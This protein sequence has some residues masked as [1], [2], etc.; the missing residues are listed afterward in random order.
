MLFTILIVLAVVVALVVGGAIL[1]SYAMR[2]PRMAAWL[3]R[4]PV[5]RWLAMRLTRMGMKA[6]RK[7]AAREAAAGGRRSAV[8]MTDLEAMLAGQDGPEAERIKAM[9]A[10]MNPRQRREFSRMTLGSDGMSG[11]MN[12]AAA[13]ASRDGKELLGRAERRRYGAAASPAERNRATQQSKAVA[14]RRA[15]KKGR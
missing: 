8:P 13:S 1:F 4:N 6:A 11:L 3:M 7:R 10:S 14:R 15:R 9:M 12:G 5:G 2:R